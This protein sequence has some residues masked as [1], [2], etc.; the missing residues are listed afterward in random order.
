[1][2]IGFALECRI[3]PIGS[4]AINHQPSAKQ[5]QDRDISLK[6]VRPQDGIAPF[7]RKKLKT[8]YRGVSA[9]EAEIEAIVM[10]LELESSRHFVHHGRQQQYERRF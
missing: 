9:G 6:I 2:A 5:R 3:H 7:L 10:A 8:P 4:G 1:M